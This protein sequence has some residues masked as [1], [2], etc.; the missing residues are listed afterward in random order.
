MWGP[1]IKKGM[2]L[3]LARSKKRKKSPPSSA[4]EGDHSLKK[5]TR[6]KEGRLFLRTMKKKW[7]GTIFPYNCFV[8]SICQTGQ[9]RE[10]QPTIRGKRRAIMSSIRKGTIITKKPAPL[11]PLVAHSNIPV[12][13][14]EN[15]TKHKGGKY[16]SSLSL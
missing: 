1:I 14:S 16:S 6:K 5:A 7:K 9:V 3:S 10:R 8:D 13:N 15:G 2:G 4:T 12:R 11:A